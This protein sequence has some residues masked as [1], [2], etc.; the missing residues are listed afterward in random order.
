MDEMKQKVILNSNDKV[1]RKQT[2]V[3]KPKTAK[4]ARTREKILQAASK[5]I[6]SRGCADFQMMEVAKLCN[7]SKGA[8]YYY[9]DDRDEI[10]DEILSRRLDSFVDEL[11]LR[12]NKSSTPENALHS[13]CM[14]FAESVGK[15]DSIISTMAMEIVR[16]G[17]DTFT[18][19]QARF[20]RVSC[21][22]AQQISIAQENG[23]ARS[24]VDPY[25]I[26]NCISGIFFFAAFSR[27]A[28]EGENLD[29]MELA[30]ELLEFIAHGLVTF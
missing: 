28:D 10:I 1:K 25:F 30:D 29:A 8:L 22:I 4:S 17:S 19:V 24:D 12:I 14:A 6:S 16:G 2:V 23:D 5:L 11:E 27:R 7:M 9:F 18:R 3:N 21:L 15:Q 13:L 26:A 20:S